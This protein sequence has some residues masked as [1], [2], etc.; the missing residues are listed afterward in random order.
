M[1]HLPL[2]PWFAALALVVAST[3]P[4][5]AGATTI[6]YI[7]GNPAFTLEIPDGWTA[8]EE[9]YNIVHP[10]EFR[11]KKSEVPYRVQMFYFPIGDTDNPRG[12]VRELAEQQA[13]EDKLAKPTYDPPAEIVSDGKVTMTKQVMRGR[14]NGADHGYV[15]FYF[16]VKNHGYVLAIN[17]A[18]GSLPQAA[19][20]AMGIV[21]SIRPLKGK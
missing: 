13:Q 16:V 7:A 21:N 1:I 4:A 12:F 17:G 15:F 9:R 19:G 6:K 14:R 8:E 18:D 5:S 2:R 10:L 11:P 20:V 3:A